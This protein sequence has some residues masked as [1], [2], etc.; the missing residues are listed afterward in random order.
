MGK[1]KKIEHRDSK[2]HGRGV[3]AV[4]RIK[5]GE[6]IVEYK[7]QLIRHEEADE[8]YY[9]DVETGHT[10]LFTLND[11]WIVDANVDGNIAKWINHSCAPNAVA[12]IHGH[13]SGKPKK[14]RVIIEARRKIEPGEEITYDYGFEFEVPYTK[15]LL[16]TWACRCGAPN[17]IG[18]ML[19]PKKK[20]RK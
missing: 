3:F 18:T 16:K 10:F 11:K 6:P 19:K 5:K 9:S 1:K 4:K 2:I 17:C 20:A 14:D 12:F 7:G 8:R 15:K 13:K